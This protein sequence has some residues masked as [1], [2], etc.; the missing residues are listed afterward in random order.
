MC[1]LFGCYHDQESVKTDPFVPSTPSH[2]PAVEYPQ[3]NE[4]TEARWS[5]GKRLFFDSQLS[6]DGRVSCASCHKPHL[7][8]SDNVAFS[9]GAH[10]VRGSKNAPTLT[11]LAYHPYFTRAGGV[12]TLEM[13]VLVPIQEHDEFNTNILRIVD[14][15][16]SDPEYVAMSEEA[17]GRS[18]DPYVITRA[19]ANFQRSLI[20]GDAPIDRHWQGDSTALSVSEERGMRLFYS[21]RL[22]C[23]ECHS[24]TQFSSFEFENN[25]LYSVYELTGRQRVTGLLQDE[26]KFKVPSLRNVE[27]TGP[28]MHDGSVETLREVI[29]HYNHGGQKHP[30]QSALVRPLG[31]TSDEKTDLVNF[32]LSL[33]DKSFLENQYFK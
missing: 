24:G 16:E 29:E 26:G 6:D 8:F 2:F 7:A 33:T 1:L 5:L 23:A 14:R 19:L 11:N 17:Y 25:G 21:E 18:W 28:Y 32:L 30:N 10:G 22:A 4:W 12:P 31:L 15:L 27:V 13:H 20:S 9:E 3:D